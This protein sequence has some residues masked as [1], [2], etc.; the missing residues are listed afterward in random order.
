LEH[1]RPFVKLPAGLPPRM[2]LPYSAR[3]I[4]VFVENLHGIK[5]PWKE[6]VAFLKK[7]MNV[8]KDEAQAI[9]EKLANTDAV[10]V[11]SSNVTMFCQCV[12]LER[13]LRTPKRWQVFFT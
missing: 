12:S 4:S 8:M 6:A 11:F 9:A 13:S 2:A 10:Y 7:N 5:L 1:N 3:V